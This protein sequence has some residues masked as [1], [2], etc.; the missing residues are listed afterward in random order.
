M[1]RKALFAQIGVYFTLPLV[2]AIIHSIF[3]MKFAEFAMSAFLNGSPFWGICVTAAL[4]AVLYGG[5]MLATYRTSKRI[6]EI[7]G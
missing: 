1:L 4:M 2:V 7:E 6:V 5:Y 3:G